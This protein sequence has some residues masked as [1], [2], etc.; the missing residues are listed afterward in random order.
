M[1][2]S[3]SPDII[4][5]VRDEPRHRF[6]FENP[7]AH[8]YDV[9][10]EPGES[11]IYHRHSEDTLYV[12]I[13]DLTS[14]AQAWGGA[15]AT[16]TLCCGAAVCR[17]HRASPLVHK[18]RNLG[19]TPMRLVGAEIKQSPL[20]VAQRPLICNGLTLDQE[21]PR[22][23]VYRIDLAPGEATDAADWNFSGLLISHSDASIGIETSES[24]MTLTCT[25]GFAAWLEGP[26]KGRRVVNRGRSAFH[27]V[28]AEWA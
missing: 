2:T 24:K 10:F 9:L 12:A 3:D 15:E 8:V 23:R 19:Q 16:S 13:T 5:D 25:P 7:Y 26:A 4:V 14:G 6:R 28:L 17:A 21:T 27:A 18:V 11:S 22:V 1:S 20:L